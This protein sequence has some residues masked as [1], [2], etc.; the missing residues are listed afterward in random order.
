MKL[1]REHINEKFNNESD[2]IKDMGIGDT[3]EVK[4]LIVKDVIESFNRFKFLSYKNMHSNHNLIDKKIEF[5]DKNIIFK[6]EF[7]KVDAPGGIYRYHLQWSNIGDRGTSTLKWQ[8]NRWTNDN[9]INN[10]AKIL[11]SRIKK[12]IKNNP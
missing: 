7:E 1:V 6:F 2:P 12:Y 5:S 8:E 3:E 4:T 11:T 9:S 10:I